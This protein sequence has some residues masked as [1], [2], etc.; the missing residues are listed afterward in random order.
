MAGAASG[1]GGSLYGG[2]RVKHSSPYSI[3]MRRLAR[4]GRT[5][6]AS[7]AVGGELASGGAGHRAASLYA[8]GLAT[9]TMMQPCASAAKLRGG[10]PILHRGS[11]AHVGLRLPA[12][13]HP[14]RQLARE[15]GG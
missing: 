10:G 6:G 12:P 15:R 8:V 2:L 1:R 11:A 13:L 9:R 5:M 3:P 14:H 4:R 7:V